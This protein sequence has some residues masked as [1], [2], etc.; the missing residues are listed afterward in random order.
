MPIIT[1]RYGVITVFVLWLL[2][3]AQCG[4]ATGTPTGDIGK[5][6]EQS[7]AGAE[8]A[9]TNTGPAESE[10]EHLEPLDLAA[11]EKLQVIATTSIIGDMVHNVAGDGIDLTI[12]I[13]TGS[14]PHTFQPAPQDAALIANAHVIFANGLNYEAFLTELIGNAGGEAVVIHL[15]EGV[16]TREFEGKH[17]HDEEYEKEA[18]MEDNQNEAEQHHR[19]AADP[20]T[21]MTPHNVLVYVHNIEAALSALDPANA[22]TYIANAEAY[23]A[24]L[25]LLD[26]WVFEQIETIPPEHRQMVTDHEAFGH[27]ADRYGLEIIGTV[28]PSYSTATEPSAREL[29]ELEEAIGEFSAPVIFTGAGVNP[30]LAE[31]IAVDTGTKLVVLYTESLGPPGSGVETYIDFIRYNTTVIVEGLTP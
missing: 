7:A 15:A 22:A 23:E 18:V 19:D 31:Q 11:G 8:E 25:E 24:Q 29:A 13:P 10:H 3:A 17:E 28:I 20:H 30:T 12:L 9:A 14:D 6:V 16:E 2:V 1:K 4:M 5:V 26:Q 21:W 27:Y